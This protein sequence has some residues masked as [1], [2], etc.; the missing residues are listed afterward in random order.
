MGSFL[1]PTGWFQS[2]NP[3]FIVL[4]GIPFS[5][6]W[7]RLGAKGKN[8]ATPVKMYLGLA[9]VALGFVCLVIAVFEMQSSADMKS[10][11]IWLVLAYFFHTTGELCISPVGLSMITKLA[12][13]RLA[14]LMMGVWFLVN[15]FGN[16]LAGYIGAFTEN[17]GAVPLDGGPRGRLRRATRSTRACWAC[18]AAS[19][20]RC[21]LFSAVLWAISGRV[22]ELDARRREDRRNE[23]QRATHRPAGRAWPRCSPPA[24]AATKTA[25]TADEFAARVNSEL[26][27]SGLESGYAAWVQRTY[28]TPDTEALAAKADER[29][30]EVYARLIRESKAFAGKDIS[31]NAAR[32]IKLLKLSQSAPAPDDP[33]KRS[34]LSS[35]E[36]RMVSDVQRRQVLP[37]G[38]GEL[39]E[40]R[41]ARRDD[42]EEPRP[43]AAARHL[44]RLARDR[45]ADPQGLP[46]LR[47]ARER[48]RD[49]ASA[50]RIWATSGG[51]ATT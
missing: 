44:D 40:L 46:A 37:A 25:E 32:T 11:M 21:S 30:K 47:R 4:L 24:A 34:E 17:M 9:Q 42:G 8:P 41:A 50:S 1:V 14:S 23:R 31:E 2:L 38:S 51:P 10:S 16:T 27:E 36:T 15:L 6:L 22:V 48:G 5:M 45:E 28:I 35:I 20:S 18:S 12:P 39:P 7:T 29:D 3:L 43:C 49:R 19:R 33:A 13:L 26:Y